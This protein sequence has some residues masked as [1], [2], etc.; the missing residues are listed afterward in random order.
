MPTYN[1]VSLVMLGFGNTIG[2]G[3]FT[4]TG[5]A[6]KSAGS[7]VFLAFILAGLVALSTAMVFAEFAGRIPKSGSAYIYTYTTVGELP[8]WIVGW[9]Q[10]LRYGGVGATMSRGWSSYAVSLL[11]VLGL[12]PPEWLDNFIIGGWLPTSPL[13]AVFIMC[14]TWITTRGS[15]SAGNFNNVVTSIKLC[16]LLFIVVVAL[17][18]F[19]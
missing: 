1:V 12:S 17:C 13:A 16:I 4:L 2:S 5:I 7:A 18:N 15:E 11:V 9:N 10:C 19:E 3:V 6:S 14:C 8:A